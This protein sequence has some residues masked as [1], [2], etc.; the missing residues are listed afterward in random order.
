LGGLGVDERDLRGR[1]RHRE[2]LRVFQLS[3]RE[4]IGVVFGALEAD[5][6]GGQ[7]NSGGAVAALA[8]DGVFEDGLLPL[9]N[10]HEAVDFQLFGVF[11][12]GRFEDLSL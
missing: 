8:K 7:L 2:E 9:G 10:S 3:E 12:L 5:A 11:A 6:G 4:R 1:R